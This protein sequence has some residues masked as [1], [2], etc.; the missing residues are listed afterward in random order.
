[1]TTLIDIY[2]NASNIVNLNNPPYFFMGFTASTPSYQTQSQLSIY[3]E[4][5]KLQYAKP[6]NATDTLRVFVGGS[7]NAEVD[8]NRETLES[9]LHRAMQNLDSLTERVY[10]RIRPE[11]S[12]VTWRSE[13]FTIQ[14]IQ[15]PNRLS[16]AQATMFGVAGYSKY[17]DISVILV[18]AP[19]W[20][21]TG[22]TELPLSNRNMTRVTGG[23]PVYPH[24]DG[25]EHDNFVEILNTDIKGAIPSPM[26]LEM[27][28]QNSDT[29]RI[30]HIFVANNRR[31][32]PSSFIHRYEAESYAWKNGTYVADLTANVNFSNLAGERIT[33]VLSSW[34]HILDWTLTSAQTALMRNRWF[35]LV[36]AFP[37]GAAFV[38]GW[39]M[40]KLSYAGITILQS[41]VAYKPPWEGAFDL[42]VLC[43]PPYLLAGT[44]PEALTLELYAKS[45]GAVSM[46]MSLDFILLM[47]TESEDG[48]M[49]FFADSYHLGLNSTLVWDGAEKSVYMLYGGVSYG[50]FVYRGQPIVLQ[51]NTT[52]RL[53]FT[54]DVATST[55]KVD[56]Y[57]T[58][59]ASYRR[60]RRAI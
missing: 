15:T 17:S 1:M 21:D 25:S 30:W 35:R 38:P 34:T 27:L 45:E 5:E 56:Y 3:D 39:L 26:K 18:R 22:W 31:W 46:D 51:P 58:V 53:Y 4:G 12:I 7:T 52:Q 41:T 16:E 14:L 55:F 19:F 24:M 28:N 49:Y 8:A 43:I 42:G 36:C 9:A 59:K 57:M 37:F 11:G 40:F 13:I 20:E 44:T 10:I 32:T 6:G 54:W 23:I 33:G 48:Y 50:H 29:N 2:R 47:P 60:R